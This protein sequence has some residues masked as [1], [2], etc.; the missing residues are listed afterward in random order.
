[1][2]TITLTIS[3]RPVV[4]NAGLS[5]ELT[6]RNSGD[7]PARNVTPI[8]VFRGDQ[9]L[10]TFEPLVEAGRSLTQTVVVPLGSPGA[11]SGT[12]PLYCRIAYADGNNH[13]FEALHVTTVSFG[14]PRTADPPVRVDVSGASFSTSG[15]ATARLHSTVSTE[16]SV[17][18]VV[19]IGVSVYPD[20][21][22]VFLGP[23]TRDVAAVVT[24]AGATA[25]SRL[26]M[27]AVAE[28]QAGGQHATA[29]GGGTLEI[30]PPREQLAPW[31]LP[32]VLA[33]L[34]VLWLGVLAF[35]RLRRA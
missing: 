6:I 29:I 15:Q 26:P 5:V 2:A 4:T 17:T 19:P 1:M 11:T 14:S 18:F 22:S 8:I 13:P 25:S 16:A 20:H 23:G 12:W 31:V 32:A 35:Q 9:T 24:N 34:I 27:F 3:A 21:A 33:A 7:A 30:T 28:F 10:G